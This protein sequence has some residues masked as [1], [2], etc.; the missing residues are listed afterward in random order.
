MEGVGGEREACRPSKSSNPR[1]SRDKLQL[2]LLFTYEM[3]KDVCSRHCTQSIFYLNL[4]KSNQI[5]IVIAI[6]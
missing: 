4:V 2:E 5:G 3:N 1:T 6:F